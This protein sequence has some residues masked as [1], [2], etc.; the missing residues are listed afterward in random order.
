[1]VEGYSLSPGK[2]MYCNTASLTGY[3]R[4]TSDGEF[5]LRINLDNS[6]ATVIDKSFDRCL[7]DALDKLRQITTL[8]A[9]HESFILYTV[10]NNARTLTRTGI[11]FFWRHPVLA[12]G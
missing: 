10:T 5:V 1:M 4:R 2:G 7:T 3:V 9:D 12:A 8:N 6:S 11:E